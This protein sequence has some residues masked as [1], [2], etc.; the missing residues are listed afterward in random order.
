MA[1]R[2]VGGQIKKEWM[3][4]VAFDE[5]SESTKPNI[6]AITFKLFMGSVPFAGIIKI[7]ITP[8]IRSLPHTAATVPDNFLKSTVL[9]TMRGTFPKVSFTNHSYGVAVF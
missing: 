6:R 9:R 5:F 4:L 7:I 2:G 8:I 3:F 1:M